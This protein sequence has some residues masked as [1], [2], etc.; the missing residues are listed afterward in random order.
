MSNDII[1]E[2]PIEKV[3]EDINTLL[4]MKQQLE[5]NKKE[6]QPKPNPIEMLDESF[7]KFVKDAFEYN[8]DKD[9]DIFIQNELKERIKTGE[10]NANQL[11]ALF[12]NNKTAQNDRLSRLINPF[13]QVALA[14]RQAEL[15]ATNQ[16]GGVSINIGGGGQVNGTSNQDMKQL[17]ANTD[18]KVLQGLNDFNNLLTTLLNKKEENNAVEVEASEVS[19]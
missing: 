5:E 15:A 1:E 11:I 4:A 9:F 18:K 2:R 13:A 8:Y 10:V 17:N 3:P 6:L 16:M 12:I 19:S 14:K 7:A